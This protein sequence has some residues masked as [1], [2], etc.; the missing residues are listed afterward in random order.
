MSK[1]HESVELP[2]DV[3]ERIQSRVRYTE[4]SS[5]DE[6]VAW[7]MEETLTKVEESEETGVSANE[8]EVQER[9]RS[10]GYLEN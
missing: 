1:M 10:L 5:V 8:E 4:F 2:A 3:I 9:L 6:Y 7:V